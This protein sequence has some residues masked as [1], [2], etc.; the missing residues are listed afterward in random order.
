MVAHIAVRRAATDY[1]LPDTA[2]EAH[3]VISIQTCIAYYLKLPENF[4]NDNVNYDLRPTSNEAKREAAKKT[5]FLISLQDHFIHE[6]MLEQFYRSCDQYCTSL[7]CNL[8][9]IDSLAEVNSDGHRAAN[10]VKP[11]ELDVGMNFPVSTS[12]ET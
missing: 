1:A 2:K 10:A 3:G 7:A 8:D 6:I 9:F 12:K 11:F 5:A 4:F